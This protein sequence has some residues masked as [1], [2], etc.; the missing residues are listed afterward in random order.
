MFGA[1]ILG[2]MFG[3]EKA[4]GNIVGSVSRGLDSL[5]YTQQE[6][7][8][9]AAAERAKAREM[10]LRWMESTQGQNLARRMI[11]VIVTSV[12]IL[13]YI[14]A[15]GLSLFA[16]WADDPAQWRESAHIVGNYAE[17][18]SGAMMLILGFYFAAPHMGSIVEVAMS[19]FGKTNE[20]SVAKG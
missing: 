2:K 10:V 17:R 16:V 9:A 12:W 8:Q 4:L 18:M 20:K 13:Q 7:E 15:M 5:V 19:K 3:S 14:A 11:A 6:K 1:G